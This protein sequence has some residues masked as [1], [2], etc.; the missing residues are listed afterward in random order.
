MTSNW[1]PASWKRRLNGPGVDQA[2]P[3]P[4]L[5]FTDHFSL[6]TKPLLYRSKKLEIRNPEIST[7]TLEATT[8]AMVARPT[9]SA[10]PVLV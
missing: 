10:P 3:L 8:E 7:E 2:A 4:V 6:I 5:S 1:F 9:P